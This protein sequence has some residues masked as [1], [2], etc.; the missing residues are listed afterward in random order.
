MFDED[1][2]EDIRPELRGSKSKTRRRIS[3]A[4]RPGYFFLAAGFAAF[5]GAA[6]AA[7]FAEDLAEAAFLAAGFFGA[8]FFAAGLAVVFFAAVFLAAGFAVAFFATAFLAAGLAADLVD[9]FLAAG[10]AAAFAAGFAAVAFFAV[11]FFAAGFAAVFFTAIAAMST[12]LVSDAVS[13]VCFILFFL[14]DIVSPNGIYFRS[15]TPWSYERDLSGRLINESTAFV[16]DC[17]C[18]IFVRVS[19]TIFCLTSNLFCKI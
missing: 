5:F 9:A 12:T 14:A 18:V 15:N 17:V 4:P 10:F 7:G 16:L 13:F 3:S 1:R 11:A 6:F 2:V 19:R 8:A